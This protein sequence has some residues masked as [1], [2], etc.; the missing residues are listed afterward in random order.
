MA[1]HELA[2]CRILLA[3]AFPDFG[4]NCD[5]NHPYSGIGYVHGF[6]SQYPHS[7]S[8]ADC[9]FQLGF[10]VIRDQIP[11]IV[12]A[13][14]ENEHFNPANE[15]SLQYTKRADGS[16]GILVRCKIDNFTAFADGYPSWVNGPF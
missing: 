13:C 7:A 11:E 16:D 14:I 9:Q 2:L 8:A 10:K 1:N 12:G 5:A 3:Q 6:R 4:R 15:D